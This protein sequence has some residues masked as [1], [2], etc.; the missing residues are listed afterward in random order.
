MRGMASCDPFCQ[1]YFLILDRLYGT[2]EPKMVEWKKVHS[3]LNGPIMRAR[4]SK[5]RS[6]LSEMWTDRF[7]IAY[8]LASAM[9]YMH[10][11]NVLYRDL[12]PENIGFDVRG[13]VKIFDLGLAKELN[14]KL[15]DA[16]GL[17]RLTGNTGSLR[18]M[19]PEIA[20]NQPYNF[21]VD[22]YSFGIIF[23]QVCTWGSL[24]DITLR[25]I[26]HN[27]LNSLDMFLSATVC[28]IQLQNA[29][30]TRCW[31]GVQ[32]EAKQ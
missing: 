26:I 21:A 1:D 17:Y 31:K 14:P 20:K 5:R 15:A 28:R 32:T 6:K 18:Y 4:P 23:W 24:Q 8:D 29:R 2:L 30:R 12:K 16:D 11:L 27:N 3:K 13:D 10:S 25:F 7:L 19:A 9:R 22:V